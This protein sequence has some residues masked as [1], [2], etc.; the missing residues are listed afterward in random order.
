VDKIGK[1]AAMPFINTREEAMKSTSVNSVK[2]GRKAVQKGK[3]F[4]DK[5]SCRDGKYE[6]TAAGQTKLSKF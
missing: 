6:G 2:L 5:P 3:A 1:E 4:P